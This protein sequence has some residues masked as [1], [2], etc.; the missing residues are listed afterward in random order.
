MIFH[1]SIELNGIVP[2][3]LSNAKMLGSEVGQHCFS[4]SL[5]VS[6]RSCSLTASHLVV[7]CEW[8]ILKR[9]R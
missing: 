6:G 5:I 9:C 7:Y 3:S 1:M 2:K 8:R 4:V